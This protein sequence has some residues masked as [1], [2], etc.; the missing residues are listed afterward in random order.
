[1]YLHALAD[2]CGELTRLAINKIGVEDYQVAYK[3]RELLNSI[4]AGIFHCK[5]FYFWAR[6]RVFGLQAC[7]GENGFDKIFFVQG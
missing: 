4:Y 3:V 6:G 2:T 5:I 7:E 1:M